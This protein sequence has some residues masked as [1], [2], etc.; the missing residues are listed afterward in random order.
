MRHFE[1]TSIARTALGIEAQVANEMRARKA[2]VYVHVGRNVRKSCWNVVVQRGE[3]RV[4][5]EGYGPVQAVIDG[6]YEDFEALDDRPDD[7]DPVPP[8]DTNREG[9]PEFNGAFR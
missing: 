5:L 7:D 6:A 1:P 8:P 2:G 9:Q 3:L 4:R